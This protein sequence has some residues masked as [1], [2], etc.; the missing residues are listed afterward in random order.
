MKKRLPRASQ[1]KESVPPAGKTITVSPQQPQNANLPTSQP[2][3]AFPRKPCSFRKT[4]YTLVIFR[5]FGGG[6]LRA[7]AADGQGASHQGRAAARESSMGGRMSCRVGAHP[8]FDQF[9]P[10][11]LLRGALEREAIELSAVSL[12]LFVEGRGQWG[13]R[14]IRYVH[15]G[16]GVNVAMTDARPLFQMFC[17]EPQEVA[18]GSLVSDDLRPGRPLDE[19]WPD[20]SAPLPTRDLSVTGHRSFRFF[21]KKYLPITS[22]LL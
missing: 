12:V 11:P 9:E 13:D 3:P 18:G 21:T 5:R 17:Q 8:S 7:A 6:Y 14:S 4:W 22:V 19:S 1:P 16:R 15:N 10:R 20:I 2:P